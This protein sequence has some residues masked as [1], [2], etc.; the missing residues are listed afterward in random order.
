VLITCKE[1]ECKEQRP[2]SRAAPGSL[3]DAAGN[4][5]DGLPGKL[6]QKFNFSNIAGS[7][8]L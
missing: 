6:K 1:T 3:A 8:P 7:I 5:K 4:I 2:V